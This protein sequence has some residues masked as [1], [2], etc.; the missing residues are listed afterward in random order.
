[1]RHPAE[2]RREGTIWKTEKEREKDRQI[3]G[4]RE[5]ER[6]YERVQA[7]CSRQVRPLCVRRRV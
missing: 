6:S 4:E 7:V 3:D 1:M 5:E 2:G